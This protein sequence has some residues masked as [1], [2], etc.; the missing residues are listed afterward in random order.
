[1]FLALVR[2]AKSDALYRP[3]F[4]PSIL[5]T[6]YKTLAKP[7]KLKVP[8]FTFEYHKLGCVARVAARSGHI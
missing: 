1:M 3:R 4:D 5:G 7:R 2:V 8:I 6:L